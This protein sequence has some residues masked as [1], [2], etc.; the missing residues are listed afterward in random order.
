MIVGAKAACRFFGRTT[1]RD[2]LTLEEIQGE[3]LKLLLQFDEFCRARGLR[4][5]LQAGTLLGA[6]RHKGFIPWDDDIDVSMPRP[7]Y[8]RLL[9]LRG[10]LP[11]G[12]S[13]VNA[14]NS[15]FAYPFAKLCTDAVRAQEPSYFGRMKEK[16]WLDIFVMD[17]VSDDAG[18][19]DR[20][21]KKL[22]SAVRRN[23]WASVNL[24]NDS[25]W[26]K[27]IKQVCGA[28]FR[29]GN[30]RERMM[31]VAREIA[32]NPGYEAA[33]RVSSVF[34]GAKRGWSVPKA[35]YENM[36]EVE[37]EGHMLPVMG[38]WDEYLTI[39]YGD[40]M[41]LPPEEE[42][43]THHLKAWRVEEHEEDQEDA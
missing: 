21:Q 35:D 8:E 19:V 22:N 29:L 37:F 32:S 43:A 14:E 34:G 26:K 39:A 15:A 27:P 16:L 9:Q 23:V 33:S 3:G 31:A 20:V 38:C 17:G 7:D 24:S 2:Y 36:V 5:S 4:Y 30:P 40:Y 10:E 18:E 11:Y 25:G 12:L 6:V 28:F 1:M 42:R 41:K 13:I